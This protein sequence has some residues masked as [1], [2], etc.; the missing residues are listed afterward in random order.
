MKNF[1]F[2]DQ[3]TSAC[4]IWFILLAP[5]VGGIYFYL[6]EFGELPANFL[7]FVPIYSY[8]MGIVPAL[9]VGSVWF[10]S[11]NLAHLRYKDLLFKN[12]RNTILI[13]CFGSVV[14]SYIVMHIVEPIETEYTNFLFTGCLSGGVS[15]FMGM[16][17]IVKKYKEA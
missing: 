13:S 5:L 11:I 12:S 16:K 2:L 3:S 7:L 9:I 1:S 4:F 6:T 17:L 8:F 15:G 10:I 14:L